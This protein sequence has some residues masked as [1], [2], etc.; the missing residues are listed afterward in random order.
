M[1][2]CVGDD[3]DN[4]DYVDDS[5]EEYVF[6]SWA[7]QLETTGSTS[8]DDD[9][10][11]LD[12]VLE[13][14]PVKHNTRFGG[15]MSCNCIIIG[16]QA[17]GACFVIDPGAEPGRILQRIRE[18]GLRTVSNILIT[19]GHITS[20]LGAAALKAATGAQVL[21]HR[22]DEWLWRMAEQQSQVFGVSIPGISDIFPPYTLGL[23]AGRSS[24]AV[25]QLQFVF[26]TL[27]YMKFEQISNQVGVFRQYTRA[28]LRKF[29]SD[30][31]L[32]PVDNGDVY[33]KQTRTAMIE[34][35]EEFFVASGDTS[36]VQ[37][38]RVQTRE[39]E[40]LEEEASHLKEGQQ[41]EA[42]FLDCGVWYP[43]QVKV[44]RPN[45]T[46]DVSFDDGDEEAGVTQVTTE[47]GRW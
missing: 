44:A 10:M 45:R 35:L 5:A 39:M 37:Q 46:Y 1:Q 41:I 25:A 21:M 27:G 11:M 36:V 28:A 12:T 42:N 29:R 32:M 19:H 24:P 40:T 43:G 7:N 14:M 33:D 3:N 2:R 4:E 30:N 20:F 47:K 18:R 15:E 38:L 31:S 6:P 17:T 8:F 13:I 22:A 23:S 26:I 16:S 9:C 34:R